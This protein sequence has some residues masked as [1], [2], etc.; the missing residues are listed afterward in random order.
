MIDIIKATPE[1]M[2][3]LWN[4]R[5]DAFVD[6]TLRKISEGTLENYQIRE[7][8]VPFGELS[9]VWNHDDPDEANGFDTATLQG[10]RIDSAHE[11]KGYGGQLVRHLLG[12]IRSRGFTWCTIGADDSDG[13]RLRSMYHHLGFTETVKA[14]EFSYIEDGIECRDTYILLRQKL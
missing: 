6:S 12:I 3:A 9:I 5:F 13:D 14:S 7:D 11:G 10:F 1:Q 2:L 4:G 8:G